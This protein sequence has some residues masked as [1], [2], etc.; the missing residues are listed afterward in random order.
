MIDRC[1]RWI[2]DNGFQQ[3]IIALTAKVYAEDEKTCRDARMNDFMRKPINYKALV[4]RV[5]MWLGGHTQRVSM[6]PSDKVD[7]M[8]MLMGDEVLK[9]ALE[10]PCMKRTHDINNYSLHW[11]PTIQTVPRRS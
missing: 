4:S 9:A 10:V 2:H 1:Y 3:P 5:D 11:R 6:P 7:E 8:R